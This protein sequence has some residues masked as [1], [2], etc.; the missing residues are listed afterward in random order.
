VLSDEVG[1]LPAEPA[2]EYR[3]RLGLHGNLRE[4][5]DASAAAAEAFA[6]SSRPPSV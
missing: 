4:P 5:G 3:N 6:V 1:K 2:L